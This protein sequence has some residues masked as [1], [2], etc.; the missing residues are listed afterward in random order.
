[1]RR[2]VGF[3]VVFDVVVLKSVE[4]EMEAVLTAARLMVASTRTAPKGV[5]EV[6]S[7]RQL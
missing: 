5:D 1:M 4:V 6:L 2:Y 3:T 7:Q